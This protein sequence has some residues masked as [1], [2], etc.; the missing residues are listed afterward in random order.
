MAVN[1]YLGSWVEILTLAGRIRPGHCAGAGGGRGPHR[2]LCAEQPC[3]SGC[4]R[5]RGRGLAASRPVLYIADVAD[6]A[7][8][9][10]MAEMAVKHLGRIDI[11]VNNAALRLEKP[12]AETCYLERR[13][14]LDVALD[15]AFH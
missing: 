8:W 3:R 5:A 11:L 2:G 9:Q 1:T 13:E 10:A 12:F 15:G 14:I 4:R 6:A 7:A